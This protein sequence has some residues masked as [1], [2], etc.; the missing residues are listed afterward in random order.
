MPRCSMHSGPELAFVARNP[1]KP[2][3]KIEKQKKAAERS[4]ILG[5][6][7]PGGIHNMLSLRVCATHVDGFLGQ[8]SLNKG[9]LFGRFSSIPEISKKWVLLEML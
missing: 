3:Q 1:D 7:T 5:G 2:T 8:N 9:S 6:Y 4:K